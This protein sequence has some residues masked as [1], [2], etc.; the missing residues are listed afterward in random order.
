MMDAVYMAITILFFL[1]CLL[2]LSWLA[3]EEK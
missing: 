1:L 3:G 2:Y